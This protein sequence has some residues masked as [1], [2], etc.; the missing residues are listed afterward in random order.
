MLPVVATLNLSTCNL[1]PEVAVIA[2]HFHWSRA[3]C[4]AMSAK[5]RRR[6]IDE[7]A[8]INKAI[9]KSMRT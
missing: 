6:W 1:Y 7:I 5:E 9:A 4:M 8:T 3:E 2:F